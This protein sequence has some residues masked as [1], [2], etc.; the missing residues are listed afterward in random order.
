MSD[1]GRVVSFPPAKDAVLICRGLR[2]KPSTAL[3]HHKLA[4]ATQPATAELLLL[5][6]P[7]DL[8][9]ALRRGNVAS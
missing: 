4:L 9:A 5:P 1:R 6:P 7:R 2:E 8:S 3:L